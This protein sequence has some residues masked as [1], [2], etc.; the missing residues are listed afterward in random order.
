LFKFEV[1]W[2]NA[3]EFRGVPRPSVQKII[4]AYASFYGAK[5]FAPN[6]AHAEGI[7]FQRTASVAVLA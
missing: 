3:L 6:E 1:R 2:S 4:V 7:E 5:L